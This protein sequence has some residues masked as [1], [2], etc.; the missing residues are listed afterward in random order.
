MLGHKLTQVVKNSHDTFATIRGADAPEEI[1][2]LLAGANIITGVRAEN[3]GEIKKAA[4]LVTPDVIVN[5]IGIVKQLAKAQDSIDSITI[6]SLLPHLLAHFCQ[7]TDTRLITLSTDCVFSG[8]SGAYTENSKTDPVDLYGRT[9]LLGEV[10]QPNCLTIRTSIIGR[11][12]MGSH[13]LVE[14]FLSESGQSVKGYKRAI[15][16]GFTTQALSEI[17][18]QV[19]EEHKDLDGLWHVAAAP[20]AKFDLLHLIR[21]AYDLPVEIVSDEAF[22]CDRS[23]NGDPFKRRTGI[24]PLDWPVMIDQMHN[25][26]TTYPIKTLSKC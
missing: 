2:S 8:A 12:L 5:C 21:D 26:P 25:D 1:R 22:I 4:A 24:V 10:T 14:W 9:K 3:F 16:S 7:Q 19:I 23:L 20:I 13:G 11:Q 17:I 6:N 18:L 15:F